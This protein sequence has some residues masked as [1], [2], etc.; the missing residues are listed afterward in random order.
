MPGVTPGHLNLKTMKTIYYSIYPETHDDG[1]PTGWRTL[2]L[3]RIRENELQS[4]TRI[5]CES[6]E[7]GDPL[8]TNTEEIEQWLDEHGYDTDYELINI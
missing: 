7:F 2:Y 8:L 6:D 1:S 5:D 4:L 3:Y